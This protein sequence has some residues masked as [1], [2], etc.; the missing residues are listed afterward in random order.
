M[1]DDLAPT[2]TRPNAEGDREGAAAHVRPVNTA[3]AP[4]SIRAVYTASVIGALA[5]TLAISAF[6]LSSPPASAAPDTPVGAARPLT[7]M[8]AAPRVQMRPQRLPNPPVAARASRPPPPPAEPACGG[9]RPA[10]LTLPFRPGEELSYD[11]LVSGLYVGRLETKVGRPRTVGGRQALTL[12]GRAFSSAVVSGLQKFE[13]RY[14]A[15]SDPA[16][17]RPYGVRVESTYGRDPRRE[18]ARF[19]EDQRSLETDYL[20]MGHEG[21]YRYATEAQLYDALSV[22]FLARSLPLRTGYAACQEVY[23]AR[24]L[25]RM[26]AK[27]TGTRSVSTPAGDKPV[28]VIELRIVR[29][30]DEKQHGRLPELIVDGEVLLSQDKTRTP[31]AFEMRSRLGN[32]R[33][34][35][36]RWVIE[37]DAHD[38]EWAL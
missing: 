6:L 33:A 14:M 9:V 3:S 31:L 10:E 35:L 37:G 17:L 24:R 18:T 34:E 8:P 29:L 21:Q 26:E 38:P 19:G 25:W 20:H 27:V 15:L 28:D 23:S 11:L 22:L 32:A 16:T 12:F 4:K 7:V 13:G 2:K 36:R 30:V 1:T 5:S